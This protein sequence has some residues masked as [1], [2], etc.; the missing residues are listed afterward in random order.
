MISVIEARTQSDLVGK[1][2]KHIKYQFRVLAIAGRPPPPVQ[3]RRG[4]DG[5]EPDAECPF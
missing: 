4:L 1:I 5:R 3:P 2:L